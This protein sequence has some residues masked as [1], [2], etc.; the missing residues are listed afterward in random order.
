[1]FELN[2][3]N[4]SH[5]LTNEQ[6]D[7]LAKN[8]EL[9]S[10]SNIYSL[11]K[12]AIYESFRKCLSAEY[13][14]KSKG[15]KGLEWNYNPREQ[16]ESGN[17]EMKVEEITNPNEIL[18]PKVNFDDFKKALEKAKPTIKIY[19]LKKYEKFKEEYRQKSKNYIIDI[20]I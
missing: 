2:L 17:I 4:T 3:K 5:S 7:Y 14:K 16:N 18:L 9:F 12:D 15:I 20:L 6:I 13:F 10:Y 11:L 19:D 1:M 8:T